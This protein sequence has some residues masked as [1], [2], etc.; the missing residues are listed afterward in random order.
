[1]FRQIAPAPPHQ[2][3]Q[4]ADLDRPDKVRGG[5][6]FARQP[7][8][9]RICRTMLPLGQGDF[10]CPAY[11][12]C[13]DAALPRDREVNLA[14]TQ[15]G[16][17][18]EPEV[19]KNYPCH[20]TPEVRKLWKSDLPEIT[21]HLLRLDRETRRLRFG[22][23]VNDTFIETY[24]K[25]VIDVDTLVYGAFLDGQLCAIGELRGLV[26]TWPHDAELALSVEPDWQDKGIG[27]L[28]FSRLVMVAQ[29]RG[30]KTLHVIFSNQNR[31]MQSIAAKHHPKIVHSRGQIEARFSPSWA[32]PLSF[33][34]E[35]AQDASALFKQVFR[36]AA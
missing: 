19:M 3:G 36:L 2:A 4:G 27:S 9:Q 29:N 28:L 21:Q 34:R 30:I 32:T 35:I 31:N 8:A 22:G 6:S 10:S 24:A 1:M 12:F 5:A 7:R 17:A 13:C 26:H 20:A 14:S 15:S 25:G 23:F 33:A 11:G 18:K 16:V